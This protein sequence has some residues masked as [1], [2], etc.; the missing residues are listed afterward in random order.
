LCALIDVLISV[1]LFVSLLVC[2]HRCALIDVSVFM[3]LWRIPVSVSLLVCHYL[4]PYWCVV[5]GV[6]QLVCPN[7][8]VPIPYW[9]FPARAICP[10]SVPRTRQLLS[11]L[12]TDIL[13]TGLC[14]CVT[15][16]H[17]VHWSVCLRYL[18][19]SCPLTHSMPCKRTSRPTLISCSQ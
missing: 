3:S 16:R 1:S 7:W 18:P 12:P 4:S 19:T 17:L 14:V 6:S 15:Y 13:S 9:C 10:S 2:L 11:V 8:R 5:N